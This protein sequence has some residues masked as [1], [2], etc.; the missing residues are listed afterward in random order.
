MPANHDPLAQW[1]A[2]EVLP[3]EAALRRWLT[4]K[5]PFLRDIDDLVQDCYTRLWRA[6]QTGPIACPR[7][8]LFFVAR[9]LALNRLRHQRCERSETAAAFDPRDILDEAMPV[10]E[11]LAH[12]E[13]LQLL[14][15]AIESLPSR[16]RQVIT[17]R[18]IYGLSQREVAAEL[19]LAVHTVEIQTGIG[20]RK[21]VEYF[22][23]HG[24]RCG[25]RP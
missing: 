18:K 17:L 5:F 21:C 10:A 24:H 12:A 19:G 9:N 11:S 16:C 7:A 22:R 2:E 25:P 20:V 8:F 3:H 23:R 13:D 4:G 15:R 6:H 1:F 14:I